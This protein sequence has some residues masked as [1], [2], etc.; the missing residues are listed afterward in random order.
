LQ[1]FEVRTVIEF[2]KSESFAITNGANSPIDRKRTLEKRRRL[3]ENFS[4]GSC[5][6]GMKKRNKAIIAIKFFETNAT[7]FL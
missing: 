1:I 6:L 3:F 7:G 5:H 2:D 4:D